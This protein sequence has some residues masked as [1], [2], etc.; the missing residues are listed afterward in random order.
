MV[1]VCTPF[2]NEVGHNGF[3]AVPT[4]DRTNFYPAKL[5]VPHYKHLDTLDVY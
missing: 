1:H 4:V 3:D 2:S 5:N